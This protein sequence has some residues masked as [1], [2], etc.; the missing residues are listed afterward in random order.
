MSVVIRLSVV[1]KTH[2]RSFRV[3]AQE[4]RSKRDGKFLEILGS[5]N[6]SLA[7]SKQVV[8]KK[9]RIAFWQ[10]QGAQ[11]SPTVAYL[12]KNGKLP[13]RPKKDRAKKE[14]AS[15]GTGQKPQED[16]TPPAESVKPEAEAGQPQAQLTDSKPQENPESEQ[17][18]QTDEPVEAEASQNT[19]SNSAESSADQSSSQSPE[20]PKAD[21]AQP[22]EEQNK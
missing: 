15:Q 7:E 20:E 6:P 14:A 8:I 2:Q 16:Q 18:N 19:S 13:P 11:L 3:S 22:A 12:V 1:G 21:D 10:K 9:D 4:K 5:V 17:S